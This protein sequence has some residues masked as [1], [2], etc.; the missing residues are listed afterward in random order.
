[1]P[2]VGSSY[3]D[4]NQYATGKGR[5]FTVICNDCGITLSNED[6]EGGYCVFCEQIAKIKCPKCKQQSHIHIDSRC[7]MEVSHV[8]QDDRPLGKVHHERGTE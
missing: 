2:V 8:Q 7:T 3:G 6:F 1:M 4:N 5:G